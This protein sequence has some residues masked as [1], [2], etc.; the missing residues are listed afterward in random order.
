MTTAIPFGAIASSADP[1]IRPWHELE[2]AV[3]ELDS[4]F[5]LADALTPRAVALLSRI[6]SAHLDGAVPR[7]GCSKRW[8]VIA[9]DPVERS[10]TQ[11]SPP[12]R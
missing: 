7:Q 1:A 3:L 4:D 11:R 9:A 2:Y 6:G 5:I 8:P 10:A 12:T